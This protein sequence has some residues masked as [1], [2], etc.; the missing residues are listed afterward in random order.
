M[1][2]GF[3]KYSRELRN[4]S[5]SLGIPSI[6]EEEGMI[7][8]SIVYTYAL[9]N[10]D[11]IV[12]VDAGAGIGYSTLWLGKALV[13]AGCNICMIEAVEK[14]RVFA[15]QIEANVK[16]H[17]LEGLPIN[18]VIG[19]AV[20]HVMNKDAESIDILFVDIEKN[21]YP[22]MLEDSYYKIRRKGFI[23]YHNALFPPPPRR[24]FDLVRSY[25]LRYTV[26]PSTAGLLLIHKS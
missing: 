1:D 21:R 26:I 22:K 25:G 8:Y 11:H 24:L 18:I 6:D 5:V 7:L 17:G 12:I 3:L 2:E 16:K 20:E 10:P 4:K 15:G 9:L 13:D 23:I 14:N 19:D